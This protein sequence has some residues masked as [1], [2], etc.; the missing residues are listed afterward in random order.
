MHHIATKFV[1]Q[2]LTN[3]QKQW[4]VNVCSEVQEKANKDI[5]FISRIIMGDESWIYGYDPKTK[6][7]S[8]QLKSPKS[9][10]A[11]KVQQVRTSTKG[12]HVVFS[13]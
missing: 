6:Q 10:R 2:F 9:P 7:Q 13:I 12:M 3:N 11:K 8:L 5:T 1:P 4:R